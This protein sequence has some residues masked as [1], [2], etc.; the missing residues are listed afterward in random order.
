MWTTF[1]I[2]LIFLQYFWFLQVN[3]YP[4]LSLLQKLGMKNPFIIG[5]IGDLKTQDMFHLMKE[6]MKTNQTI[7]VT[8]LIGKSNF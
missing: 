2:N 5:E 7:C 8:T 6:T 3:C 4:Y 1:A